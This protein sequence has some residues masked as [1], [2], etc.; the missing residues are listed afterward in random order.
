MTFSRVPPS[1]NAVSPGR[2]LSSNTA[3]FRG[4]FSRHCEFPQENILYTGSGTAALYIVL[5]GLK[6][7]HPQRTE[8]V[9]PAWG[10]PSV[11]QAILQAGLKPVLVDLD[12]ITF[13]YPPGGLASSIS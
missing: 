3:D 7:L 2:M 5:L 10:C 4:L 11:P 12:P 8:V 6:K 13:A 1:G 9:L